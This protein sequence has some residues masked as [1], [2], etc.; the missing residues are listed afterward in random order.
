MLTTNEQDIIAV[1][2]YAITTKNPPDRITAAMKRLLAQH[3][4]PETV[5]VPDGV[6]RKEFLAKL[7]QPATWTPPPPEKPD[8]E[9]RREFLE[10]LKKPSQQQ[11][12]TA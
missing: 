9:R 1:L 2:E 11:K 10:Q 8:G 7:Q 3:P 6:R 5:D 4:Q 12:R